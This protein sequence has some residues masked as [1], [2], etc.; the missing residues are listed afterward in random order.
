MITIDNI[1]KEFDASLNSIDRHFARFICKIA[2]NNDL[3][4][5]ATAALISNALSKGNICLDL[6]SSE[7]QFAIAPIFSQKV[8]KTDF[9]IKALLNTSVVGNPGD[10]KPLIIEKTRIYLQK[11]WNYEKLL[12]DSINDRLAKKL[13]LDNPSKIAELADRYFPPTSLPGKD[14]QKQAALF[15]MQ[16]RLIIISGGPGTGK[17]TTIAKIAALLFDYAAQSVANENEDFSDPENQ[18]SYRII[19]AAPTGKAAAQLK[20][21][22]NNSLPTLNLSIP[23]Q[24]AIADLEAVTIHRLLG[25]LPGGAPDFK[26]NASNPLPYDV[27]IIDEASMIDLSLMAKLFQAIPME[28]KIIL[29]GDKDQLASVE[30]GAI[31]NDIYDY[32]VATSNRPF[33]SYIELK[34]NFRFSENSGIKKISSAIIQGSPEEVIKVFEKKEHS[35]I[36]LHTL[37]AQAMLPQALS[38]IIIENYRH[39]LEEKDPCKALELFENFRVLC[40]VRKGYFGVEAINACIELVLQSAGLI[41]KK[42]MHYTGRPIMISSND[43][44]LEVFN[45]DVGIIKDDPENKGIVKAFFPGDS[46]GETRTFL[47]QLL[48]P[49]ETVFAMTVHKAQGSQFN[50]ELL[51]L[52]QRFSPL[53][54]RELLYTAITR[55]RKTC[56]I[57]SEKETLVKTIENRVKRTSGLRD[58]LAVLF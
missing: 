6:A 56:T 7:S 39:Y 4:L 29:L 16:K 46:P 52:P 58:K 20:K 47:P 19:L 17:T 50:H 34:K 40:A 27:V 26:Y 35:D 33:E 55:A 51:L 23:V 18:Q 5:Y 3:L 28:S 24:S 32:S 54:S 48:P 25:A 38:T 44:Q 42:S 1:P 49:H 31:L 21:T 30:A 45:G 13:H 57:W 10:Y 9:W 8:P 36:E 12:A 37:P 15:A 14:L 2:N 53:L 43:Y 22:I 11:Y 41:N